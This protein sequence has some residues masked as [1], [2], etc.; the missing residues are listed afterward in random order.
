[1]ESIL[2]YIKIMLG[3]GK[4]HYEFDEPIIGHINTYLAALTQLGVGPVAGFAIEDSNAAWSEF[5]DDQVAI[6]LAKSYIYAKV[7]L[8]FDP[9]SNSSII[10]ILKDSAQEAEW[11]LN[12]KFGSGAT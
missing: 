9:P 7:R 2:T 1:M 6:S 12:E 11:K 8:I 10:Q 3:V 4:D 5:I